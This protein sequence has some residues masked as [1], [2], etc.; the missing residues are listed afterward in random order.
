MKKSCFVLVVV[1]ACSLFF[2]SCN[3]KSTIKLENGS[4]YEL[5]AAGKKDFLIGKTEVTQDF[6][7]AVMGENPSHNKQPDFPAENLSWYDSLVFC[8]KLSAICGKTPCYSINGET[9]VSK[10]DYVPHQY[11]LIKAE[12]VF[13]ETADGYHIPTMEEWDYAILG[14]ENLEYSGS[15]DLDTVAWTDC[16]AGGSSHK[17]ASLKP[18]GY[19]IYDMSGNVFEW[20]WSVRDDASR[21]CRGGSWFDR[22]NAGKCTNKELKFASQQSKTIGMRIACNKTK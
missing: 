1:F 3:G 8:N 7:E 12:I 22:G 11:K 13:D 19:G 4:E 6:Y 2:F 9:D 15:N 21:Y 16:N 18:N 14:G 17:V 20:V 5:V 10:W